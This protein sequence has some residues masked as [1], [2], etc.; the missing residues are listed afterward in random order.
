M[1]SYKDDPAL[2]LD[3]S[4][5]QQETLI[6]VLQ[7]NGR[8]NPTR[9]S[10]SSALAKQ[11][12]PLESDKHSYPEP[13]REKSTEE[14]HTSQRPT[15]KPLKT[16][17]KLQQ[18]L[19]E[20]D[21]MTTASSAMAAYQDES[22]SDEEQGPALSFSAGSASPSRSINPL[23]TSQDRSK[24]RK[25]Q[26]MQEQFQRQQASQQQLSDIEDNSDTDDGLGYTLPNLPVYLSDDEGGESTGPASMSS[27]FQSHNPLQS[28]TPQY[29][30]TTSSQQQQQNAA[31]LAHQHFLQQQREL[32]LAQQYY[33]QLQQQQPHPAYNSN[34]PH[35]PPPILQYPP[36]YNQYY[37]TPHTHLPQ[38][39]VSA[40]GLFPRVLPQPPNANYFF[41]PYPAV[42]QLAPTTVTKHA[43]M[44]SNH[45]AWQEQ[46]DLV[47]QAS[48]AN[49]QP[50]Q[51]E[52]L[53]KIQ[54]VGSRPPLA[55]SVL[56]SMISAQRIGV[57]SCIIA[58]LCYAAV[59]PRTLHY[60]DYNRHFYENLRRAALVVIPPLIV[61]SWGVVDWTG[62][63]GKPGANHEARSTS[64][65]S[66]F[67]PIHNLICAMTRSFT[68]GYAVIFVLEIALTTL[69]RLAVFAWWEPEMF[70]TP[71]PPFADTFSTAAQHDG[72]VA[73]GLSVQV[74]PPAWLILPWV[75]REH[76]FRVKRITLLV[77]DF[78]TSCVMSPIVEEYFKLRLLQW[79][80][81]L[82]K[83]VFWCVS[84]A[85]SGSLFSQFC[86]LNV[87]GILTGYANDPKS[88]GGNGLPNPLLLMG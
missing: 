49:M 29:P 41:Q 48:C 88:I 58:L 34:A 82:A 53:Q 43:N 23:W 7:Q 54:H 63:V 79:N 46:G 80:M 60:L 15:S 78:V 22:G 36:P 2:F 14:G 1:E 69:L 31:N 74:P 37:P 10:I 30:P 85:V 26:L 70:T 20:T 11:T 44:V 17:E 13:S 28:V 19:D 42:P 72:G 87:I 32:Y 27:S 5:P 83:Y 33:Q 24:Y 66:D 67:N 59:S 51:P 76:R 56:Q 3:P 16:L 57:C 12:M 40:P 84:D 81:K 21:Y 47:V 52:Y 6:Q 65:F 68:F 4:P 75:L 50:H 38:Q 71:K 35:Y 62:G 45:G 18:L 55:F 77:A 73:G 64:L 86:V 25:Q 61:Y 8:P 39:Q 9:S